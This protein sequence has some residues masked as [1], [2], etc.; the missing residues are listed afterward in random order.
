MRVKKTDSWM[1]VSDQLTAEYGIPKGTLFRIF[2]VDMEI[3]RLGEEDHAYS[4]DWQEGKQYWFEIVHDLSRDP[5]GQFSQDIRMID[6]QDRV[7]RMV[8]PVNAEIMD[9]VQLWRRILD[10][11]DPAH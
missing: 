9:I 2:P 7:D 5:D 3:D 10:V 1:N 8:I 4:F 6:T 11:P